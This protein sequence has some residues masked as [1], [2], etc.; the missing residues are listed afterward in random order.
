M[1]GNVAN[2]PKLASFVPSRI[3]RRA[4]LLL[5]CFFFLW[6]MLYANLTPMRVHLEVGEAAPRDIT[7][8]KE[9]IDKTATDRLRE[10]AA[11]AV[12]DV[13]HQ[14]A[15][16]AQSVIESVEEIFSL[17]WDIR[18]DAGLDEEA[19]A[20]ELEKMGF[21]DGVPRALLAVS[22]ETLQT[23]ETMLLDALGSAM[24][25][26]IKADALE[27]YRRQIE[28]QIRSI[29][30]PKE[31]I[32]FLLSIGPPALRPNLMFNEAETQAR[33]KQAMDAV[34][35]V[36]FARGEI[37]IRKGTRV[38]PEHIAIL[39]DLGLLR[40][41]ESVRE[42]VGS[43]LLA[44][45]LLGTVAIYLR[46]FARQIWDDEARLLLMVLVTAGTILLAQLFKPISFY[47]APVAAGTMLLATLLEARL[48]I[49]VGLLI[50]VAVSMM[51]GGDV[52]FLLAAIFSGIAGV[53][54]VMRV[55]QRSDF[56]RAG[57]FV[58]VSNLA[59]AVTGGILL[60]IYFADVTALKTYAWAALNGVICGILTIGS[61][62]Y[63]ETLFQIITPIKLL[64]MSNPN[65]PL[66]KKLLME[67]PGTYHHSVMVANL[68][69]AATEAV[70]G[71]SLLARVGAYYHDIG[72]VKRPYFFIDNQFGVDN[73]HEKLSPSLSTLIIT[74]H[75]K[76]GVDMAKDHHLPEPIIEFIRSH[77]GTTLVSFFYTKALDNGKDVQVSEQDFRYEG[78]K[79]STR[80]SAI[81]MLADA[82]EASVRSLTKPTPARIEA[83]VR[84]IIKDRLG[85]GQ[86]DRCDLTLRDLDTIADT[87]VRVLSGIFHPRIEYPES[88]LREMERGRQQDGSSMPEQSG[89]D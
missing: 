63:L 73:P 5:M 60:N 41:G 7:V 82:I 64:E 38:T 10:Q 65:Q 70:G 35:P 88:V 43:A 15:S 59:V 84:K 28:A 39:R 66:L 4:S 76:D 79:P 50:S 14:D 55:G 19:K 78:P 18:R 8:T 23:A 67:A 85:D 58:S 29:D 40:T 71:D 53:Y 56:M 47:L 33:K 61:L 22:D 52:G 34:E 57:F 21:D 80:E 62:P 89:E 3:I 11:N 1:F 46:L 51:Y 9:A 48:A 12:P 30:L 54:G 13:Y 83:V 44:A 87:F 75:V 77:H 69:E 16:V 6:S 24:Q 27:N 86:L 72:K 17:V 31:I 26:G 25:S 20:L 37:V 74:S 45:V 2:W 81:V 42:L 49:V 36:K 68:A 32:T